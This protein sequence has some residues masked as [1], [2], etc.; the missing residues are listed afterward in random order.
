MWQLCVIVVVVKELN[1]LVNG[2][3]CCP[4]SC[5]EGYERDDGGDEDYFHDAL[6]LLWCSDEAF[7]GERAEALPQV[8]CEADEIIAIPQDV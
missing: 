6:V 8:A 3:L 7:K 1:N 5:R 4:R 2:F